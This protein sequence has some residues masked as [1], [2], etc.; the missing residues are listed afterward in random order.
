MSQN[1]RVGKSSPVIHQVTVQ[2][3]SLR[4][5]DMGDVQRAINSARDVLRPR[6]KLLYE[7]YDN[8]TLDGHLQ[9]V[10]RKRI[11]NVL[12]KGIVWRQDGAPDALV[13]RIHED[14]LDTPWFYDLVEGTMQLV[15]FGTT[16]L[17]LVPENGLIGRCEVI[18]RGN[19]VPELGYIAADAM[20]LESPW[21]YYRED[22]YWS[23]Y[24][25]EVGKP[26]DLGHMMYALPYVLYKRGAFADWA[27]F[28]ELFGMPFRVGKYNPW[29]EGTRD[30]LLKALAE[31]GGA[32]HAVIPDDTSIDFHET[33]G[34]A[35]SSA[36]YK[37]LVMTSN[38]ELSK[39]F[40]G[41]TLTTDAGD[42]GARS[43]GDVHL[44]VEDD[45]ALSDMRRIEFLL[46][47]E[48][49]ERLVAFGYPVANGLFG[50]DRSV[51]LPIE[52]RIEVDVQLAQ[53]VNI[54]EQYWYDTYGIPMP[55]SG[56]KVKVEKKE[57]KVEK[58]EKE[59]KDRKATKEPSVAS[60]RGAVRRFYAGI[61]PRGF[62]AA[63]TK[64]SEAIMEELAK[65]IHDGR[66]TAG[67]VDP[68]LMRWTN[69]QLTA[70]LLQGFDVN[71]AEEL[72]SSAL[73]AYMRRNV[74]VFSGFKTYQTL[75]DATDLLLTEEGQFRPFTDFRDR[76]LELDQEYNVRYLDAEYNLGVASAQMGDR[77]DRIEQDA[78][79]FPFLKFRTV[80]DDRVRDSHAAL[81]G[82][83]KPV[84]DPF[85]N[86][87]YPPLGWNCRCDVE[88]VRRLDGTERTLSP[89]Q[90]P[91]L[92]PMFSNNVG[93]QGTVFP[94]SH[95]Y[96]QAPSTVRAS[97]EAMVQE[98]LGDVGKNRR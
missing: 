45:I 19:V 52:K 1:A 10:V 39:L 84:D 77:W 23:R 80:G 37:D 86:T 24:I 51:G 69:E 44:A 48:L 98:Q 12:N 93:K 9:A 46:N 49:K 14:I 43:L 38:S 25:M 82:V 34:T 4:S 83:V 11:T 92:P 31:M 56:Q 81:D 70:S 54:P 26:K 21:L 36:L 5:Q 50:F 29:D 16:L 41:N 79:L 6:R 71:D 42:K 76:I 47:W 88:Q 75:R 13:Q 3:V 2:R 57:V 20:N 67:W 15:P 63:G 89:D 97:V 53:Q 33:S 59:D 87:H 28:S 64:G 66:L 91:P 85:W 61:K 78:E 18:P 96:Y 74:A 62:K 32:G 94:S 73:R 65:A 68:K 35:N 30:K 58:E 72:V 27:Q 40:L 90:Y 7:L 17:E 8:L 22:K 60:L 95:P 55:G